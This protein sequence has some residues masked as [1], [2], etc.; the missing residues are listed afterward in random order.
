MESGPCYSRARLR[1][2]R[3]GDII[4]SDRANVTT[5]LTVNSITVK[6]ILFQ[7]D[8]PNGMSYLSTMSHSRWI[9][10]LENIDYDGVSLMWEREQKSKTIN[11]VWA[12]AF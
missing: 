2:L 1:N 8:T 6:D 9:S 3:V 7:V 11:E 5:I 12:E 4:F 10:L